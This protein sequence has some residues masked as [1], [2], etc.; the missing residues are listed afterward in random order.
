[1]WISV[2]TWPSEGAG[3]NIWCAAVCLF[4]RTVSTTF[5]WQWCVSGHSGFVSAVGLPI[6]LRYQ[7]RWWIELIS[8]YGAA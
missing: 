7:C 6:L 5:R 4:L 2:V 8:Q 1:M 3:H